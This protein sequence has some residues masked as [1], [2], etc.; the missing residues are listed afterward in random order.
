MR[1]AANPRSMTTAQVV[2]RISSR[3]CST[4]GFFTCGKGSVERVSRIRRLIARLRRDGLTPA[5]YRRVAI[6]ALV[7]LC[8][9]VATG[10]A[11]R[12]TD[13]GLGC[14]DWPRCN[15]TKLIDVSGRHAAIEQINRLFTGLVSLA[16]VA[17]VLG[18]VLR[19]PRRRD[20]SWLAA[21]LVAGVVAQIVLGGITV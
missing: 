12:L 3:R 20:L 18:A 16:V 9:I 21:G 17:A 2:S 11:V 10:A 19:R 6:V 1:V 14:D 8:V 7:L 13:S 5:E 4:V 15:S